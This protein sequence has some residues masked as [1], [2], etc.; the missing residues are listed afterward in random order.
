MQ[1]EWK[2]NRDGG[3][4]FSPNSHL[5]RASNKLQSPQA[6]SRVLNEDKE[7]N[8]STK[9]KL[10]T[11]YLSKISGLKS[12]K[13]LE[14]V[15]RA[16]ARADE[17][18]NKSNLHQLSPRSASSHKMQSSGLVGSGFFS[19]T[20]KKCGKKNTSQSKKPARKKKSNVQKSTNSLT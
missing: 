4:T 5:Q 12:N 6:S 19:T 1:C 18:L 17:V 10:L 8:F 2:N 3:G 7:G 20:F 9:A 11:Q 13:N 14:I 16:T 15:P